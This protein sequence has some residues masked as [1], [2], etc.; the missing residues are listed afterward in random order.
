MTDAVQVAGAVPSRWI[1]LASKPEAGVLVLELTNGEPSRR[2]ALARIPTG[3]EAP[4]SAA[5]SL[6]IRT[7]VDGEC[8]DFTSGEPVPLPCR[9]RD[10]E[11]VPITDD[12]WPARRTPRGQF[13]A[14]ATLAAIGS[15]SLVTGYLLLVPQAGAA[16]DWLAQIDAGAVETPA[17]QEKWINVNNAI[18]ITSA[19]GAAALVA[20][21]PLVLPKRDKTP[22]PAWLAGGVGIGALAFSIA[23]GVTAERPPTSCRSGDNVNN[24]PGA[25]ACITHA[26]RVSAAVLA[27]TTAAPLLTIPL[28]YLFRSGDKKLEPRVEAG[29]HGGYFGLR[30]AF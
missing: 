30:G 10:A 29:R 21:M 8:T 14:G 17:E 20:A 13:V 15:A 1:L 22:W 4:S 6:A 23:Y 25:E 3:P 16:N 24:R 7:L 28:V 2:S 11:A 9:G 5:V 12:G 19:V 26:E 27:G 18:V